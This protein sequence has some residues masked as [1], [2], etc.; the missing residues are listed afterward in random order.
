TFVLFQFFNVVNA[1]S[2]NGTVFN[3]NFFSNG[4]LWL[5]LAFVLG[6]QVLAVQWGPAQTIFDTVDLKS[7]D[8]WLA[9]VVA[10]SVLILDE[11]RKLLAKL[12][13]GNRM[14]SGIADKSAP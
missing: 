11:G 3:K 2:E 12:I 10:S 6:M 5:A 13:R 1:R 7:G 8:W 14:T 4:K 9:I